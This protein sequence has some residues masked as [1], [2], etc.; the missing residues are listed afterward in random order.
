MDVDECSSA[1][2]A[3][4]GEC[5]DLVDGFKCIC[6]IGYTGSQCQ[7]SRDLSQFIF[8]LLDFGW[9]I[10]PPFFILYASYLMNSIYLFS[11]GTSR[12]VCVV[13]TDW[14]MRWNRVVLI[15]RCN[16]I[17]LPVS[18]WPHHQPHSSRQIRI[19]ATRTR[20]LTARRASTR[21]TR[22]AVPTT[23]ASVRATGKAKTVHD[24]E[25]LL[26]R[27]RLHPPPVYVSV[28]PSFVFFPHC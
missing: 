15:F 25:R 3:N 13:H 10:S 5:V 9:G 22:S 24:T 4:G 26:N 19:C 17:S 27:P 18:L 11:F 2:C 8:L 16:F 14:R 1:P 12:R 23:I 21:W 28:L 7:V 6:P 20:A